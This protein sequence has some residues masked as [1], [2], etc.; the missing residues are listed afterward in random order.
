[1]TAPLRTFNAE[2]TASEEISTVPRIPLFAI[3]GLSPTVVSM[4][5]SVP[6]Q[7]ACLGGGGG[8]GLTGSAGFGGKAGLLV[9]E[10]GVPVAVGEDGVSPFWSRKIPCR[11]SKK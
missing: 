8:V 2:S 10:S 5:V 4:F 1:M 11:K 6:A 3:S 7:C 9:A